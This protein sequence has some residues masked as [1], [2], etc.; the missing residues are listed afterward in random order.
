MDN[1]LWLLMAKRI[2]ESRTAVK[3]RLLVIV[4]CKPS[5]DKLLAV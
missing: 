3:D 4:E 5:N 1:A 2:S